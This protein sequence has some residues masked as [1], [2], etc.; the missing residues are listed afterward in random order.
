[1]IRLQPGKALNIPPHSTLDFHTPQIRLLHRHQLEPYL[2]P[3]GVN[4]INRFTKPRSLLRNPVEQAAKSR[5][6]LRIGGI[7]AGIA[8]EHFPRKC[9][10]DR[11][12]D[13]IETPRS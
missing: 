10:G 9:Y 1:M 7:V 2:L 11:T 5:Q 6:F 12:K 4:E 13:Q 8:R 3:G